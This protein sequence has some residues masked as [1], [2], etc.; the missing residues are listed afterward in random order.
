MANASSEIAANTQECVAGACHDWSCI[1]I[2]LLLQSTSLC[3]GMLLSFSKTWGID[4]RN[5]VWS[6]CRLCISQLPSHPHCFGSLL[7]RITHKKLLLHRLAA[8]VHFLIY[9]LECILKGL[10][11]QAKHKLR[12]PEWNKAV[13]LQRRF[14]IKARYMIAV[15]T[16]SF[17]ICLYVCFANVGY[18]VLFLNDKHRL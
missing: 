15:A 13:S 10:T 6:L 18:R 11:L 3:A 4:K 7:I 17:W 5:E 9:N 12:E 16:V 2:Y 1:K 14:S 8:L